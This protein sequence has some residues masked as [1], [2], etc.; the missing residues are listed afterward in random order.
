MIS[1]TGVAIVGIILMVL[2]LLQGI[3]DRLLMNFV[4]FANQKRKG[5]DVI[6]NSYN[7]R[8]ELRSLFLAQTCF[9]FNRHNKTHRSV[10]EQSR[11]WGTI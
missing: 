10:Q 1:G 4:I 3:P 9:F 7:I 11:F 6:N 5:K 8:A 2:M